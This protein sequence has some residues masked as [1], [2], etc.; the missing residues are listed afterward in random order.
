MR[1][2]DLSHVREPRLTPRGSLGHVGLGSVVTGSD[3]VDL[4]QGLQLGISVGSQATPTLRTTT[5]SP[6]R[7]LPGLPSHRGER[8]DSV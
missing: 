3:S 4:G 1:G 7:C 6:H 8:A 5:H 2:Q